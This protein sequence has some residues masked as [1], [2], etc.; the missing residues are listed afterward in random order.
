MDR[1]L[2]N[3]LT[4]LAVSG[5]ALVVALVAASPLP[6]APA[7]AGGGE[8][9]SALLA[10]LEQADALEAALDAGLEGASRAHRAERTE[11]PT[12]RR[13][14]MPYFTFLPRG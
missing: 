6:A 2:Q 10:A 4:A 7:V 1:R 9:R 8:P 13:I 3:N 14:A 5:A 11:T 12:H